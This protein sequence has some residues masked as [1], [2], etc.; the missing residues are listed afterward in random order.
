MYGDPAVIDT[1]P[2]IALSVDEAARRADTCRDK[3]YQAINSGNLRARKNGRRTLILISDLED[4]LKALPAMEPN[5][6]IGRMSRE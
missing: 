4:Y 3:I 5:L 6:K 1:N 2:K